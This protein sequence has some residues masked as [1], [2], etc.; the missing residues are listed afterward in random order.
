[1]EIRIE[2]G[3]EA[4]TGLTFPEVVGKLP[5]G[6]ESPSHCLECTKCSRPQ[7]SIACDDT[8]LRMES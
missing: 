4:G 7:S 8:P 6:N 2:S 3:I 5:L 1:M